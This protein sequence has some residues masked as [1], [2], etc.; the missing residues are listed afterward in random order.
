MQ[1]TSTQL[2]SL[3]NKGKREGAGLDLYSLQALIYHYASYQ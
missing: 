3:K 2:H 1:K